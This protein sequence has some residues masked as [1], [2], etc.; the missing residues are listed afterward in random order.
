MYDKW[1]VV[2]YDEANNSNFLRDPL[3]NNALDVAWKTLKYSPILFLSLLGIP[4][5]WRRNRPWALMLAAMIG[6]Q[7]IINGAALDWNAGESYGMRRMSELYAVYGLLAVVF[8][9]YIIKH[10]NAKVVRTVFIAIIAFQLIYILAFFHFTWTHPSGHFQGEPV[11]MINFLR[12]RDR[13]FRWQLMEAV[14]KSHVG[15]YAWDEPG[16]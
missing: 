6:L 8:V 16:P 12:E 10:I 3:E 14:L 2:P 15:P 11:E 7:L 9:G 5:L 4:V 1:L 13:V